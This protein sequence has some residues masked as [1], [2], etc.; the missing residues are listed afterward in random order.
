M[1]CFLH[2]GTEKTA[3][4]TIQNFFDIN[5]NLLLEN[6]VVFT[7][8]AGKS[9]NHKLAGAAYNL[10][11]RDGLTK[12][13]GIHTDE[14]LADFQRMIVGKLKEELRSLERKHSD[15]KTIVFSSEHIQSR[16]T[17]INEVIRLKDILY[18]LGITDVSVIVYL[19]SPAEIANSLYSTAIKSGISLDAPPPP[20]DLYWNNICNHKQTIERFATVFGQSAVIPKLFD[21]NEFVNGS[22]I[23]DVLQETGIENDGYAVPQDANESLSVTGVSLLRRIN[24]LVPR[25]IDD[26]PNELRGDI[27]SYIEKHFSDSKYVM[28]KALY[29]AYDLAFQDSNEWVRRNYFPKKEQLFPTKNFEETLPR[30]SEE[31]LDRIA[32]LVANVW[33]DKHKELIKVSNGRKTPNFLRRWLK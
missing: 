11:K 3:T 16:L 31:E 28:P 25:F 10:D 9:N 5:R 12:S 6:G 15:L 19:R 2:I 7:Q 33:S 21:K 14:Q 17:D 23:D 30:I 18:G 32:S 8:N 26:R 20:D 13:N 29:D 24:D 1:K 22:I 27:V 4:T